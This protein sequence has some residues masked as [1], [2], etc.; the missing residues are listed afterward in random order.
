MDYIEDFKDVMKYH[1]VIGLCMVE[2]ELVDVKI[3]TGR[4]RLSTWKSCCRKRRVWENGPGRVWL[5]RGQQRRW[6]GTS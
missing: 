1:K 6:T 3:A 4:V 2:I 5:N